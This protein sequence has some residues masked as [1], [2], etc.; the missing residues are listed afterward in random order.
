MHLF[1]HQEYTLSHLLCM[2][3]GLD[4]ESDSFEEN[5]EK[6]ISDANADLVFHESIGRVMSALV[7]ELKK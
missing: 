1:D 6:T 7:S 2:G 3:S 4:P 5:M